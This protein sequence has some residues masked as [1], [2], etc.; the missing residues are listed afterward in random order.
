[1]TASLGI[2]VAHILTTATV[3]WFIKSANDKKANLRAEFSPEELSAVR[4]NLGILSETI[5]TL[6]MGIDQRY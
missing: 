1:M 5:L 2:T 6:I 4:L 3:F